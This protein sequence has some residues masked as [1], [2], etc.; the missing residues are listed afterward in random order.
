MG[1]RGYN[2]DDSVTMLRKMRDAPILMIHAIMKYRGDSASLR[3]AV[4][5]MPKAGAD[6]RKSS[7]CL[8]RVSRPQ[9]TPM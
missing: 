2:E 7:S 5:D 8:L 4:I 3:A 1:E 6:G 9:C